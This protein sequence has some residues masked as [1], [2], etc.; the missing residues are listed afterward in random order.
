[1][2]SETSCWCSESQS[3][4]GFSCSRKLPVAASSGSAPVRISLHR[5]QPGLRH[6]DQ[7]PEVR[8]Q[9]AQRRREQLHRVQ[10]R[11][12]LLGDRDELLD[13]RVGVVRER[14]E[15]GHRRLGLV[16]ERREHLEVLA[17]ALLLAAVVANVVSALVI[18]LRSAVWS[19]PSAPN[20][21]P[22]FWIRLTVAR[23]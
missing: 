16:Q 10:R 1:M 21:V 12:E 8:K 5:R 20:T 3:R 23:C 4:I 19:W 14:L 17:S 9:V 22:P 6:R 15:L 11:L 2:K 18:R 7:R 13:Q